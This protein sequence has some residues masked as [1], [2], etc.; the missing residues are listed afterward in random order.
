MSS[1]GV[2]ASIPD[3]TRDGGGDGDLSVL[4]LLRRS[5]RR[6]RS[7]R[8]A[9]RVVQGTTGAV[10]GI[11]DGAAETVRG[12]EDGAADV[13]DDLAGTQSRIGWMSPLDDLGRPRRV[14]GRSGV[15][16]GSVGTRC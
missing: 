3:A 10:D 11:V 6:R 15:G 1:F 13:V 5:G 4:E 12:A 8:H 14:L 2:V 16:P 7:E 9:R